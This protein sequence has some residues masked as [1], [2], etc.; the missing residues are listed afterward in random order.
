MPSRESAA[1]KGR[2]LLVEGRLIVREIREDGT[3][4][5][6]CRGDSGEEYSLGYDST[7]RQWRCTCAEMK[8]RC[9]HL[10]AVQLVTAIQRGGESHGEHRAA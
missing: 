5:A 10:C 8:G 9:S 4:V 1:D 6:T 7:K 3:I 2:R